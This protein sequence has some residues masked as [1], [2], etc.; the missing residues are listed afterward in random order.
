[1]WERGEERAPHQRNKNFFFFKLEGGM[2]RDII[3]VPSIHT[4]SANCLEEKRKR[5][6]EIK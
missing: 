6:E 5:K 3:K 2:M 1:V 4:F